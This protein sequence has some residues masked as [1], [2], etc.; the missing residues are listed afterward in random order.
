MLHFSFL[1]DGSAFN[2]EVLDQSSDWLL[3]CL[4]ESEMHCSRDETYDT[5]MF[6]IYSPSVFTCLNI[7]MLLLAGIILWASIN[8]LIFLVCS[9]GCLNYKDFLGIT[10]IVVLCFLVLRHCKMLDLAKQLILCCLLFFI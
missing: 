6:S 3:E 1:D 5:L 9:K 8:K 10:C 7:I 4:N 2:S